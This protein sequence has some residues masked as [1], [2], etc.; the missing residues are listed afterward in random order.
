MATM[1]WL[2]EYATNLCSRISSSSEMLSL[3]SLFIILFCQNLAFKLPT[4]QIIHVAAT[5]AWSCSSQAEMM[6]RLQTSRKLLPDFFKLWV[7]RP[8]LRWLKWH[9]LRQLSSLHTA[10]SGAIISLIQI[11]DTPSTLGEDY[12]NRKC[13][14]GQVWIRQAAKT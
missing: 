14:M 12:V 3:I 10:P 8:K 7:C 13:P 11:F 9:H 2:K 4:M 5:V 6:R 1:I